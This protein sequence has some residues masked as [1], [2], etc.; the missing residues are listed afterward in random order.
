PTLALHHPD[1]R[2]MHDSVTIEQQNS[3]QQHR[4]QRFN[5]RFA[6]S[7]NYSPTTFTSGSMAPTQKPRSSPPVMPASPKSPVETVESPKSNSD[8]PITT[9]VEQS[10]ITRND[11]RNMTEPAHDQSRQQRRSP[12][13]ERCQGCNEAWKR[14]LPN[15]RPT[16]AGPTITGN[17]LATSNMS[18][19]EQLRAH[20]RN[21]E[22]L[23]D[24][25]RERH[26]HCV[27]R[28][29]FEP[30]SKTEQDDSR[31][32]GSNGTSRDGR[33]T[34]N[35]PNKRLRDPSSEAEQ[36]TKVRKVTF[37]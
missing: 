33:S 31:S 30:P 11:I 12:S 23:H 3:T 27:P 6:S 28:E 7:N 21:A 32:T 19:I 15:F 14:P 17:D 34:Q 36:P 1:S 13:V 10:Q 20:G 8:Q 2:S 16:K 35:G 37:E 22:I 9:S 5:V 18:I 25:W 26:Y 24:K 4:Q 29:S